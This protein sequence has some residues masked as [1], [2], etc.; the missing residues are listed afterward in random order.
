VGTKKIT[1]EEIAKRSKK[2]VATVSRVLNKSPH[3]TEKTRSEVIEA[4]QA[5]G[6]AVV[7]TELT[8]VSEQNLIIFNVP[9][10]KNPFYSPIASAASA[11]AMA[12]GYSVLIN[13]NP[14][15]ADTIDD[16]IDLIRKTRAVGLVC[17]NSLQEAHLNRL[18]ELFPLVICCESGQSAH[19]P[20]VTIDD[21]TAAYNAVHHILGFKKRRIALING[22]NSFKYSRAR[23]AGY[24]Q[25]LLDAG[26][27]ID[28]SLITEIGADM[29][30]DQAKASCLHMLT[31]TNA[32]DAFFCISDVLAAAAI[33]AALEM[34]RSVPEDIIVVGFDDIPISSIMNPTITTVRQPTAQIGSLAIEMVIKQIEGEE[35]W[36]NSIY[37]GTELI[38]RE[39][40]QVR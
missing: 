14:I 5:M 11:T 10:L 22:P 34:G 32:P 27:T 33:K 1:Y 4:M 29:D 20:F 8:P 24:R 38:I 23:L 21:E 35:T 31:S 19:V 13:E 9:T 25:A 40:S 15:T 30:F 12:K 16:L 18:K 36:G 26:L 2:S 3:V 7:P 39:S 28:R 6:M 37:L 17:A